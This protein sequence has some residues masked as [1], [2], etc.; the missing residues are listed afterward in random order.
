MTPSPAPP[1]IDLPLAQEICRRHRIGRPVW[2]SEPMG[3]AVN[4]SSL[5]DGQRPAMGL[6]DQCP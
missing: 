4:E 5:F 1:R 2:V 6:P 3:G